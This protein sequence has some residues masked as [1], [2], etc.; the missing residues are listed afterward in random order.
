MKSKLKLIIFLFISILL[1][2]LAITLHYTHFDWKSLRYHSD[3][4]YIDQA[5]PQLKEF[6]GDDWYPETDEEKYM[7]NFNIEL[8]TTSRLIREGSWLVFGNP[9][10]ELPEYRNDTEV[11]TKMDYNRGKFVLFYITSPKDC[12]QHKI[13]FFIADDF[14]HTRHTYHNVE[15]SDDKNDDCDCKF[16]NVRK[17]LKIDTSLWC[18]GKN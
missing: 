2:T 1:I 5:L 10:Y 16:L 9:K 13:E 11:R 8:W 4:E 17:K 6:I 7:A 15:Y 3:K 12:V 14:S 18:K